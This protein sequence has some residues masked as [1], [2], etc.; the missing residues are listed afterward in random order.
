MNKMPRGSELRARAG[1]GTDAAPVAATDLKHGANLFAQA[2]P[3]FKSGVGSLVPTTHHHGHVRTIGA[4]TRRR[5]VALVNL[6]YVMER[7]D[8]ALVPTLARPLGCAWRAGPAQ[9][10]LITFAR[11][12]V[13]AVVCPLGGLM[14]HYLDRAAV[15]CA[16]C[17]LWGMCTSAFAF[18][19]N[20][21]QGIAAWAFNG[22]GLSLIIPNSQ[23]LVA[24]YYSATQRGEAFGTLMLTGALGGML[25]GIYATNLGGL[26]AGSSN[27]S[28]SSRS[29][30]GSSSSWAGLAG[31]QLVFLSV[32]AASVAV[33][34]LVMLLGVDPRSRSPHSPLQQQQPLPR[35]AA[36]GVADGGGGGGGSSGGGAGGCNSWQGDQ[37]TKAE[38]AE[39][40]AG[41]GKALLGCVHEDGAVGV[42]DSE[43]GGLASG[44]VAITSGGGG[45]GGAPP[46]TWWRLRRMLTTPTFLIIILQ[47]I[48]GSTPWNALV[49]LT[50]YFQL[51]GFSDAAASGLV[52]L[53]GAGAAAGSLL[54]GWLGDRAAE[55]FPQHGRIALVQFS[56]AVGIPLTAL[57]LRGLPVDV[58]A[59]TAAGG[60]GGGVAAYGAVLVTM[61]LLIT[62]ASPAC[63]QPIFAE[64]VPPD[65]R[66]LVYAFDRAFEGAI[67]ALGA[68]LVG[69]AAERWFGFTGVAADEDSCEGL[70]LGLGRASGVAA[71]NGTATAGAAMA[72]APGPASPSADSDSLSK[73]RSLGD[74][75]LLFMVVPWTLCALFYTGL[76]WTYPRDRARAL[77]P[78]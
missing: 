61:G 67:S 47:G 60:G 31:W 74:A 77:R 27:S 52:A 33:G 17:V 6:V 23:S 9:L 66:N 19:R 32:G 38:Q 14:G 56:V 1:A 37:T 8:E 35:R 48:V 5:T 40:A 51:L 13:Q 10:G 62:W 44:A 49:F 18:A 63:N 43:T 4:G 59:A 58:A 12:V 57:L 26:P 25:G 42:C 70:G 53:F 2:T 76:H 16:G 72:G 30:N 45:G 11:A 39:E 65:M 21:N 78:Q 55:R 54:G 69:M 75:M 28:S 36:A 20:V 73:A 71:A 41:G 24:D 68:P 46:L 34:V 50:L 22:V 3:D 29:S 7:L 64:I 15:L